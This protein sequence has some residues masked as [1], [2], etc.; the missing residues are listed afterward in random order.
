MNC[1]VRSKIFL[2]EAIV[3]VEGDVLSPLY[4]HDNVP[5]TSLKSNEIALFLYPLILNGPASFSKRANGF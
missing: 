4:S 2:Y 1:R 5:E 3:I